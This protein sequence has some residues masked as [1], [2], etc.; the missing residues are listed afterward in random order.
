MREVAVEGPSPPSLFTAI[1][2]EDTCTGKCPRECSQRR[3]TCGIHALK[4][5]QTGTTHGILVRH[6][7]LLITFIE[8]GRCYAVIS[9][10]VR[11]Y[12]GKVQLLSP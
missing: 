9:W 7:K 4:L 11:T 10:D 1:K 2:N 6:L 12:H 3:H 5:C 8:L